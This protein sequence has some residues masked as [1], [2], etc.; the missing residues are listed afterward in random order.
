MPPPPPP[1]TADEASL[2]EVAEALRARQSSLAREEVAL[3][4]ERDRLERENIALAHEMRRQR[5]EEASRFLGSGTRSIGGGGGGGL[6]AIQPL[7]APFPAH[8]TWTASQPAMLNG[9]YLLLS[10]IGKG[11]FSEVWHAVDL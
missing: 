10:L 4:E 9:R 5:Y 1:N 11:E 7:P 2:R 6:A 3:K 8:A